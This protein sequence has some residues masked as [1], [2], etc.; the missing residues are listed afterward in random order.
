MSR[1]LFFRRLLQL[2]IIRIVPI[3]IESIKIDP[4]RRYHI[5]M[6]AAGSFEAKK[7]QTDVD[8]GSELQARG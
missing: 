1:V 5:L 7:L 4:L 6:V 2:H 3:T 8:W